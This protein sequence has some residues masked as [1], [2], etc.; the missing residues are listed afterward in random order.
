MAVVRFWIGNDVFEEPITEF[1]TVQIGRFIV[2]V[3]ELHRWA[4]LLGVRF[5]V[6]NYADGEG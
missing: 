5:E 6:V 2:P 4:Q 3:S 1:N